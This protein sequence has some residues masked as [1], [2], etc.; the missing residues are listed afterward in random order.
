MKILHTADFHLGKTLYETSLV[1]QQKKMLTDISAILSDGSYAALI[2]AGDIFDRSIPPLESI[3]LLDSFL[4]D[5]RHAAPQTSIFIIPGNHDSAERLSFG[6]RILKEGKI[7]IASSTSELCNG[8]IISQN[9]EKIQIFLMPFLHLGSITEKNTSGEKRLTTQ[10]DMVKAASEAL[11]KAVDPN[12]P[13]VLAAHLFTLNGKNSTEE[14]SFI[15][16][17]EQVPPEFLNFFSYTALG[18]LHKYQRVTDRMFYSGSPLPYSFDECDDKKYVL[19]VN[20]N[21]T[22]A[23]FPVEVTPI[24]IEPLKKLRRLSGSFNEF[25][26]GNKFDYCKD[27]FL[28]I[29]LE[30]DEVVTNPM[31][32]LRNKFPNLL[33]IKQKAV[34]EI[35]NKNMQAEPESFKKDIEDPTVIFENFLLFEDE[36]NSSAD[37]SKR[38]LFKELSRELNYEA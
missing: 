30:G 19:S 15:G 22:E 2:I 34:E 23:G 29:T 14:R 9:G 8:I 31:S 7:F 5:V 11:K 21:C 28:E 20:I 25:F 35:L 37:E 18:H 1:P 32:L 17:A 27:D 16:T 26:S 10:Y 4:Y 38:E 3:S 33:N 13:S 36:I 24:T 12:L 6:A